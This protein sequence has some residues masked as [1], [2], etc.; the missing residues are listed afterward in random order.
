M[1][2]TRRSNSDD[3]IE[4]RA[5]IARLRSENEQLRAA[6]DRAQGATDLIQTVVQDMIRKLN[7]SIAGSPQDP[8]HSSAAGSSSPAVVLD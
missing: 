7:A 2:R 4:A 1:T 6:I 5:E 3:L 8:P